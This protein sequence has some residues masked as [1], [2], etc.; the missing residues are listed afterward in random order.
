MGVRLQVLQPHPW[1]DL[2]RFGSFRFGLLVPAGAT[3]CANYS[4]SLERATDFL[5]IRSVEPALKINSNWLTL[6]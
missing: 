1:V 6:R 3:E 4:K 2:V 5:M